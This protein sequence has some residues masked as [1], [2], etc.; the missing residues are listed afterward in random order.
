MVA[1]VLFL[2]V[3][4]LLFT[5]LAGT[6]IWES[7]MQSAEDYL[8]AFRHG[9]TFKSP[10]SG[11]S[12]NGKP[13]PAA[14]RVLAEA[15]ANE[16]PHV[17]ENIVALLADLGINTDP[18]QP[19]GAEV[20]RDKQILDALAGPGLA[21]ADLG[22]EAAMDALRKLATVPDLA[23][24][25]EAITAALEAEPTE[26]AFLLVAKAKPAAA[27][28]VVDELAAQPEWQE[29]EAVKIA[30]AALGDE[31]AEDEFLAALDAAETAGDAEAFA[32]ALGPVALVGTPRSLKAIGSRMRTPLII[33]VPG[34][35]E[36]SARLNVMEALLYNFPDRPILYPNNVV[37]ESDY[38]KVERFCEA[39]LGVVFDQPRPPFLTYFGHPIPLPG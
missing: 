24:R 10:A 20:V 38:I 28:P 9:E 2:A 14:V 27:G 7:P 13:D 34:A 17:R 5:P 11:L 1:H 36:K 23:A 37:H 21:Q 6:T 3:L 25:G 15:L 19:E 39:Q 8:R 33:E 29:V 32:R 26:E 22:R 4:A 31:Q 30:K 35:F 16:E 12:I 18:L